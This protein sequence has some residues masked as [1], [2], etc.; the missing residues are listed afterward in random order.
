MS[1]EAEKSKRFDY[2][3]Y[4]QTAYDM[5][6]KLKAA[7]L[8]VEAIAEALAPGRAKALIMTK[9]EEAYMWAGKATRDDQIA[10]NGSAEL[11]EGRCDDG[12]KSSRDVA[13][14]GG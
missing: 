2:V 5:Q 13:G 10:R 9:L 7:F 11:Q 12:I 6:A 4:D 3:L 1:K 8:S 14:L